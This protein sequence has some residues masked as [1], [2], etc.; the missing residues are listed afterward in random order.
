[1]GK[2]ELENEGTMF[3]GH[4]FDPAF[5]PIRDRRKSNWKISQEAK[6]ALEESILRG[7]DYTTE[8]K[9]IIPDV[10]TVREGFSCQ[11]IAENDLG[12]EN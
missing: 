4:Y 7:Q 3:E 8:P 9:P 5:Q 11:N 10:C 1:M 2:H 6:E 12:G